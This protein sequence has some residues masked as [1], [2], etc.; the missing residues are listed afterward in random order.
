MARDLETTETEQ[1]QI[2]D[3]N[4]ENQLIVNFVKTWPFT[5]FQVSGNAVPGNFF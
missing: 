5:F 4:L 1:K 3:E 2:K